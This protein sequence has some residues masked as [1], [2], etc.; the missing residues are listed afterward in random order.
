[1]SIWTQWE[2]K[3]REKTTQQK[4]GFEENEG[5]MVREL[6]EVLFPWRDFFALS[7]WIEREK[8]KKEEWGRDILFFAS[9]RDSS[10][11]WLVLLF[12]SQTFLYAACIISSSNDPWRERG[13]KEIREE[14]EDEKRSERRERERGKQQLNESVVQKRMTLETL[15]QKV[16]SIV[17]THSSRATL[18]LFALSS[19]E[20]E[21]CSL[22]LS[23]SLSH[24][25]LTPYHQPGVLFL[26]DDLHTK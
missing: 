26:P 25:I 11:S 9:S 15:D 19:L 10:H 5:K 22:P 6:S 3:V 12:L 7:G 4:V 18:F 16:A 13:W 24:L 17:S 20:P 8:K 2:R 1:M 23:L 14:R 21:V